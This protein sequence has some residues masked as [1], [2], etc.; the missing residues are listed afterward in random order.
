MKPESIVFS[1]PE[2]NRT[3][4]ETLPYFVL[5]KTRVLALLNKSPAWPKKIL[6][7]DVEFIM[8]LCRIR[9]R[10][11]SSQSHAIIP[12]HLFGGALLQLVHVPLQLGKD[13]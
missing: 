9:E 11:V 6:S 13:L 1:V 10:F 7:G 2:G 12:R 5:G 4:Q 8:T 3:G